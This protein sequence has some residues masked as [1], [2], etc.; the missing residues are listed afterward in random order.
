[1]DVGRGTIGE[2]IHVGFVVVNE[3]DHFINEVVFSGLVQEPL[4]IDAW[5]SEQFF[6]AGEAALSEQ[7]A[8]LLSFAQFIRSHLCLEKMD[9]VFAL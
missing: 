6:Y 9:C 7:L 8:R 3:Y 2:D 5:L 4:G 1:M